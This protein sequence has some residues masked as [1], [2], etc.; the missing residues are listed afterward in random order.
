MPTCKCCDYGTIHPEHCFHGERQDTTSDGW[1]RLL[2]LVEEA[3]SDER[4]VFAPF[5]EMKREEAAQV[6]ALPPAIGKLKAV[7]DLVLYGSYLVR[8]P[9]EIGEMTGLEWFVPYTSWRLHWFPFEITRCA[10]L[11]MS[12]VSTRKLYG[13]Y[14]Y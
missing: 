9:Q 11:C 2:D 5:G 12:T 6:V 8:I 3:A 4:E 14:K 7:K 1:K 10:N 13:N